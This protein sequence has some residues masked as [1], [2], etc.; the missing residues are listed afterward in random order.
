MLLLLKVCSYIDKH[1][2]HTVIIGGKQLEQEPPVGE[3]GD[4]MKANAQLRRK[5]SA[6]GIVPP[7]AD[8]IGVKVVEIGPH[9]GSHGPFA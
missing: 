8:T 7:G 9:T 2:I 5:R 1:L 3:D 6:N 4:K